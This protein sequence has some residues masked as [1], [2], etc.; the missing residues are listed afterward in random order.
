MLLLCGG[1]SGRGDCST[2]NL[3]VVVVALALDEVGQCSDIGCGYIVIHWIHAE[4]V[5]ELTQCI[6]HLRISEIPFD[7]CKDGVSAVL[8][9]LLRC[10]K[11]GA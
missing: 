3:V 1:R 5:I 8:C 2:Q 9:L 4:R 7:L 10:A 11:V 6:L